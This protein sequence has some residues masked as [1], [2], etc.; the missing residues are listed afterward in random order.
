M[1]AFA[2]DPLAL[3]SIERVVVVVVLFGGTLFIGAALRCVL[4]FVHRFK[5]LCA[6]ALAGKAARARRAL[7]LAL[8]L[9]VRVPAVL[10]S[11]RA[12]TEHLA[13]VATRGGHAHW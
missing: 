9:E 3:R 1:V 10:L 11:R 6:S 12:T 5:V 7:E 2:L 8:R 4:K 13:A